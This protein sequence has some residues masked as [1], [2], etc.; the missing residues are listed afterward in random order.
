MHKHMKIKKFK[1]RK[2]L[3]SRKRKSS[4][5][6]WSFVGFFK[7]LF[8]WFFAFC[9]LGVVGMI[10]YTLFFLPSVKDAAQLAFSES[11]IIYDRAAL[12]PAENPDDHILYVIHGDENRE[13]IP[14]RDIPKSVI[15]A[16][17][18]IEDDGFYRHF[19]F[20]IGGIIKGFL[21]HFFGIGKQR[22]G[23]TITQ[24]LVKNT[25][26]SD[27]AYERSVTRKFNEILLAIKMEM[28]YDKDEILE[29]YLNNIPYGSSA[30][31]IAA[32]AKTFLNKSAQ[33][34]TLGEAVVLVSLPARPTYF[35]PYGSNKDLLLGY[36]ETEPVEMENG[37]EI[38]QEGDYKKGRKD[39]VLDRMYD[40]GM[41][42]LEQF[43]SAFSEANAIEFRKSRID[44]KAPHFV[45]YVRQQVEDMFGKE[46]LKNGGLRIY[47]TLDPAMQKAAEELIATKTV[48]Y[49]DKFGAKNV[50]LTS[51]NPDNGEILAYIGG[52]NFFDEEQ[53]GQVDVLTSRRQPG[54]SFKPFVYTTAFEQG[55]SPSTV[56]F[57]VETDF[58]GNYKPQNFDGVFLGPVSMRESINRSLNIPAVKTAFLADPQKVMDLATRV[59][60]KIDGNAKQHG[61]ALGVGVAEVE[62]LSLINAYQIFAGDGA[63]YPPH[64]I[65]EIQNS[66]GVVLEKYDPEKSRKEGID[67]EIAALT[68]HVLTDESTRPTTGEE[69]EAFDWNI[70]LQLEGLNNGVKTGTSNRV[71]ENPDFNEDEPENEE[72]NPKF[73]TVPGDSWTI[74]FTPYL[75]T[76]VWV[77]NNKGE[78]MKS[79]ATGLTVAAPIWRDFMHKSHDILY[80]EGFEKGKLY[81][82]PKPLEVRKINKFS[83]K[84][85]TDLTPESLAK[86]EVFASFSVPIE[87]DNS[88]QKIEI[89]RRTG[90]PVTSRTPFYARKMQFSLTGLQSIRPDMPNWQA[91]VDEWLESHP[92]FLTSLGTVL[93]S[94][95]VPEI[96]SEEREK[97]MIDFQQFWEERRSSRQDVGSVDPLVKIQSPINGGSIARGMIEIQVTASAT[98]GVESVQYYLNDEF[99]AES[100]RYPFSVKISI[101]DDLDATQRHTITAL[102][103]DKEGEMNEDTVA[104]SVQEDTEGPTITFLGPVAN[105]KIINGSFVHLLV[106]AKDTASGVQVVEF[107]LDDKSLGFSDS[108]P[109]EIH[110]SESVDLGRHRLKAKAWDLNGNE[111]E[112]SIEVEF[113]R[114]RIVKYA[115]PGIDKIT[116]Y[117]GFVSVDVVIPK[118]DLVEWVE[119]V[120]E[121]PEEILY[122]KKIIPTSRFA[123]FQLQKRFLGTAQIRLLTKFKH[124]DEVT[125]SPVREV[126]L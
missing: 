123:Q 50:A 9:G 27:R 115:S 93:E 72:D 116:P 102:I 36:Y 39:L 60:I 94:D 42:D 32:A 57:D 70:L 90:K 80:E 114:E 5:T 67:Q 89:D 24:Q 45:F 82:E 28:V 15:D 34:L 126:N 69:E 66:D 37:E 20:D 38:L 79:G 13:Y 120:A 122:D 46:F 111:S 101:S 68:R 88:V 113:V 29:M 16:T 51:I 53:D 86:E 71:A 2:K 124:K 64:S 54:S 121:N 3:F 104:V 7:K 85:A 92:Q 30:H 8:W 78:P 49:E 106:D 14:L 109:F 63:Y 56:L 62:P 105:Q 43:D 125:E 21:S 61:V 103:T 77:G 112:K 17:I 26:L 100:K 22:G 4:K 10:V 117:P 47:T 119:L 58:G 76:G 59:G 6:P 84:I 91:P 35:S 110:F 12:D 73:I 96:S 75:V 44:I 11:T 40:L 1:R 33:D 83:G 52:K 74:G 108:Y 19:G 97:R 118:P 81:N 31:G 55:Y 48:N 107:Y 18:A 87:L 25:F 95:E 99:V 41:I 98:Q 23:S 65:L